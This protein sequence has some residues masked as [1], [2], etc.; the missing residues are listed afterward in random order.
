MI[1]AKGAHKNGK[2]QT[3]DCSGEISPV[4]FYLKKYRG[5]MSHD[6]EE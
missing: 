6:T 1:F 3:F 5:V 4:K 2:F